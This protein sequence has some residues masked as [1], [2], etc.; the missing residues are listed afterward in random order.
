VR[1]TLAMMLESR[2]KLPCVENQ[3]DLKD[4]V[5]IWSASP[6][7]KEPSLS[8]SMSWLKATLLAALESRVVVNKLRTIFSENLFFFVLART[9]SM[10]ASRMSSWLRPAWTRREM[11]VT[12][13]SS[14]KSSNLLPKP[15]MNAL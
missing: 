10:T 9:F 5:S 13:S 6:F 8:A 15:R 12:A 2:F 14:V 3:F 11:M 7:N 4:F 1:S